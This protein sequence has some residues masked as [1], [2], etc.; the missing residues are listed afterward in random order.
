VD[1]EGAGRMNDLDSLHRF[2]EDDVMDSSAYLKDEQADSD[3]RSEGDPT[4]SSA[5]TKLP[6]SMLTTTKSPGNTKKPPK[7][8]LLMT[9]VHG[10]ILM[11]SGD[12]FEVNLDVTLI[13]G[14]CS[15]FLSSIPSNV[16]ARPFVCI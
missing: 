9:L 3:L 13:N 8:G 10:D 15:L 7:S 12:D 11:L 4:T 2:E 6:P 16:W 1:P 14:W 5:M